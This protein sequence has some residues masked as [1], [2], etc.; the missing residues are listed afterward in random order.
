[1]CAFDVQKRKQQHLF[2]LWE[3][4]FSNFEKP[5]FANLFDLWERPARTSPARTPHPARARR[6]HPAV[7]PAPPPPTRIPPLPHP[8]PTHRPRPPTGASFRPNPLHD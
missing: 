6:Q 5:Y 3:T 1:M 2:E 8:I 7:P 4:H